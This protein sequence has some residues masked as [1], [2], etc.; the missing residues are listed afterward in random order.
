MNPINLTM[1]VIVV[2]GSALGRDGGPT[3]RLRARVMH[4]V[5]L[6]H[7]G[8][9]DTLLVTGGRARNGMAEAEVMRTLAVAAGVPE[10]RIVVDPR[11]GNT[12]ESALNTSRL[13]RE[14]GWVKVLIATDWLHL[15]RA[16]LAFRGVGIRAAGS[17]PAPSRPEVAWASLWSGFALA[18]HELVGLLW[19]AAVILVK[20][21][22]V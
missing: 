13:M 10:D 7:Q 4:G 6:F 17:A 2:L 20:R 18:A 21:P 19:Y 8:R 11:A 16:L 3:P 15:M 1:P 5:A 9:A 22:R 14:H 12:L